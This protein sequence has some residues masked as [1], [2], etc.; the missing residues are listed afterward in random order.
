MEANLGINGALSERGFQGYARAEMEAVSALTRGEDPKWKLL[1]P[2]TRSTRDFAKATAPLMQLSF[3]VAM[4]LI[5]CAVRHEASAPPQL[6]NAWL[7]E[8]LVTLVVRS[9]LLVAIVRA[10]PV[11]VATSPFLRIAPLLAAVMGAAHWVWTAFI[12]IGPTLNLVTFVVLLAFVLLSIS[13][14]AM[15][16]ASPA[17]CALYLVAL[18]LAMTFKLGS[19][20]WV[21]SS[22]FLILLVAF[23]AIFWLTFYTVI[24]GTRRYLVRS[25]AVDL[26]VAE[27]RDRNAQIESLREA[28]ASAFATRSAFFESASHDFRQRVHAMKLLVQ[29]AARNAAQ[30]RDD[31][32]ALARLTAVVED[33][34]RYM[35][36]VLEFARL[37]RAVRAPARQDVSLQDIFQVVDVTFEEFAIAEGVDLRL[38]ATPLVIRTDRAMLLRVLENLVSNAIKFSRAR[39]LVSARRRG[40]D[41]HLEVRDQGRG[42]PADRTELVFDAFYQ[43]PYDDVEG[44]RGVGLGLAIVKRLVEALGYRIEVM[45]RVGRGTLM[46]LIVPDRDVVITNARTAN[47]CE[48]LNA[49]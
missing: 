40:T 27:L 28:A 5:Y 42:I 25:D 4:T 22:T 48:S 12:F 32:G 37:E 16:P 38:R 45:S 8:G 39:V 36:D 7:A 35:T 31:K 41:V 9:L 44:V 2:V 33:L 15:A 26:L 11:E 6:V 13:G 20:D 3:V 49:A 1:F 47:G 43:E 21:G 23:A 34:E 18:W 24:G 10:A 14:I 29:I 46:R 17:A 30:Q 19:A